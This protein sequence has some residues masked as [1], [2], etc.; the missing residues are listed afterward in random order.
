MHFLAA[1]I[2]ALA[3]SISGDGACATIQGSA[4]QVT[5]YTV[6]GRK[7]QPQPEQVLTTTIKD[8]QHPDEP[9]TVTTY[10]REDESFEAFVTRHKN[11]CEAVRQALK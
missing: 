6:D 9:W 11:M 7:P 8:P 3:T 4:G 10:R 2:L 5:V 1:L